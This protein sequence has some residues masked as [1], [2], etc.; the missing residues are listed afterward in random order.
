MQTEQAL[1]I[2]KQFIDISISKGTANS[3]EHTNAIGQAWHTITTALKNE[4]KK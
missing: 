2:L 1:Q 3:L 4:A